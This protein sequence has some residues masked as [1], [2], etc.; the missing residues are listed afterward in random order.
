[1]RFF[2]FMLFFLSGFSLMAQGKI[3]EFEHYNITDKK[4]NIDFIV[5]KQSEVNKPILLFCQGSQPV[6]LFVKMYGDTIGLVTPNFDLRYMSENHHVVVLSRPFTPV[7][8]DTSEIND[9]YLYVTDKYNNPHSYDSS[10]LVNDIKEV[11]VRRAQ[12]VWEFLKKQNWVD[13]SNF[14][15]AGHS[16]GAREAVAIAYNNKEVTKLGLFGFSPDGRYEEMVKRNRKQAEKGVI[17]WE[18]ADSLNARQLE[19]FK[20]TLVDYEQL[21]RLSHYGWKSFNE[22]NL[23]TLLQLKI[24]IYVAYGSNDLNS[25]NCDL[26]P[27]YFA[28]KGKE[29]LTIKRYGGLEHNFFPIKEDGTPDY[30]QSKWKEVMNAFIDWSYSRQ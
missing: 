16:Q 20:S 14:V 11:T 1:M 28:E 24:P 21:E 3:K 13:H 9:E 2:L 23:P 12:K 29:N 6:P 22:S 5:L 30:S 27:F 19:F 4:D 10:Y 25:V 15:V 7:I 17:T 18:K 8:A 26:L